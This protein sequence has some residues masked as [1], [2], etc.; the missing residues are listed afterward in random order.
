MTAMRVR[1]LAVDFHERPYR[2]RMPFRFGVTT[3]THGRQ[4][5]AR[6]RIGLE[7]GREAE[8]YAAEALGA[9]WFDKNLALSDAQNH[10]QLRKSLELASDAYL[11]APQATPFDLFADH[12]EAHFAACDEL[13][14]NA[15]IASYGQSLVDRATL[16]AL[17][18][19]LGI[20]F[21]E[22]MRV[23]L[24]GLRPHAVAP[25]LDD[26]D[27]AGLFSGFRPASTIAVRHTVGL[28]DPIH[29]ADLAAGDRVN[30]GLPETL[31]E[32]VATHGNRWFKLKIS[33]EEAADLDRLTRIAS[34]LD[35][36]DVGYRATLDGNEQYADAEAIAAFYARLVETPALARLASAIVCVEQPINRKT[37][38]EVP[39][40]A[41]AE[42]VPVI[43]DESDG[44]LSAFARARSLG[45][46]GVS[47]KTCKGI[48]KSMLNHARCRKWNAQGGAFFMSAEDLTCEPGISLQQDLA[49][50]NLL[51]LTHVERN[52]HHF[53]DGFGGRPQSECDAFLSAHPDLYHRQDDRVRLDIRE[54]AIAIGSLDCPGFGT[55]VSPDLGACEAMPRAEWPQ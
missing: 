24:V 30:D 3:A 16:D 52:A 21:Y 23:N 11:S 20:S 19:S 37:A 40:A 31:E 6:V 32:V 34:V 8:G 44:E 51:G 45:Y 46:A 10:H 35:R 49:L 17:C 29:A 48:Y 47:S 13:Q 43:I 26:R 50:V 25:D 28:S 4:A 7:D 18:R 33:G 12:Y 36:I 41:L 38:L 5:I 14:L 27:L 22:A 1:V 2:L 42:H 39:I 15:L 53:I 54:G 55:G 9:K